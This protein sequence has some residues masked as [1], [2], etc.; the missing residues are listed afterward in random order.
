[1]INHLDN[2]ISIFFFC[3][4]WD[5]LDS[6]SI[7]EPLDKNVLKENNICLQF[8][9]PLTALPWNNLVLRAFLHL[10]EGKWQKT[11]ADHMIFKHPEKLH[12]MNFFF[13]FWI[14]EVVLL[15]WGP[16]KVYWRKMPWLPTSPWILFLIL[17]P[18][19]DAII[20]PNFPGCWKIMW[21]A[22]AKVCSC[23]PSLWWRKI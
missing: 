8:W 21:S 12:A 4:S 1:M 7:P 18:Q 11:S 3:P 14:D 9:F 15:L 16:W 13:A 22:N 2:F 23:P 17:H 19:W 5:T 20:T 10:G 6:H